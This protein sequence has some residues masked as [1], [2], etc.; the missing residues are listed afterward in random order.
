MNATPTLRWAARRLLSTTRMPVG[1]TPQVL[2]SANGALAKDAVPKITSLLLEHG[3]SIA[4]TKKIVL[5]DHFSLMLSVWVPPG[6]SSTP[7]G[8]VQELHQASASERLGCVVTAVALPE[9]SSAEEEAPR[10]PEVVRRVVIECPQKPGIVLALTELLKDQGCVMTNMDAMTFANDGEIF[11][12]LECIISLA[13]GSDAALIEEQLR[14]W[15]ASQ[16]MRVDLT[17]DSSRTDR[18]QPLSGA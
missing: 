1:A 16:Q 18:F 15:T 10:S 11:F 7:D 17:F 8:L 2:V 12:R 13:A 14:W 3:A 4:A 9:P 5:H 6:S